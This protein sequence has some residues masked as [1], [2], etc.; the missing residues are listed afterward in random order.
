MGVTMERGAAMFESQRAGAAVEVEELPSLADALGGGIGTDNRYTFAMVRDLVDD[1]V[2]V[3]E[4]EIAGAIR[5]CSPC[6]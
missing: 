3:I 6:T 4:D 5:T 1:M 2:L